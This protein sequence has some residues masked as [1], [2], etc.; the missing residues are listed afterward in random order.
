MPR[1]P[2]ITPHDRTI[3]RPPATSRTL[4]AWTVDDIELAEAVV[5]GGDLRLAAD[6]CWSLLGDGRVGAALGTRVKGLLKLPLAWEESGDGRSSG[7]VV[8]ALDDGDFIAAHSE[9][10]LFSLFAWGILLGIGIAQRVWT[11]RNGRLIGVLKPYNA[12]NLRWDRIRRL[13]VVRT[14]LGDVDILPGNR[15]WVLYAPSCSGMPDGDELPWMWGAWRAAGRPWLLKWLAL[16]DFGHHMQVHGSPIRTADV[17]P[18][19]PP[20]GPALEDLGNQLANVGTDTTLI[21]VPGAKLK[22]LEAT[23]RTWQMFIEGS[24]MAATEIVVALTGQSSS[25]EIAQG[26]ET[27]STLHGQVRQ[28][29]IDCDNETASTCIREQSLCDYAEL[30]FGDRELAPWPKRNTSPPVNV[31]ARG[32]AWKALADGVARADAEAPKGKRVNRKKA[33][34]EAGV[35]LEDIPPEELAQQALAG[36]TKPPPVT[37]PGTAP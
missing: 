36:V 29:L 15:R 6:L 28:D 5:A 9:A 33:Y 7:R 19:K 34:E 17:D 4:T 8:K 27:G 23:A 22:Y 1:S 18:E 11:E 35:P 14:E 26:Q 32:E 20:N 2:K 10:A 12:R 31:K 37:L 16:G 30:N 25:T 13:W 3:V 24:K 21:P